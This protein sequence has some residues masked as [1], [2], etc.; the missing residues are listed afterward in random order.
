VFPGILLVACDRPPAIVGFIAPMTGPSANI[1]V[2]GV[3]GASLAVAELNNQGG[4]LGRKV[5]LRIKDDKGDPKSSLA[6]LEE[7]YGDGIRTILYHSTSGAA[8]LVFQRAAELPILVLTHTV[9]DPRWI[10]IKDSILRFVG[11]IQ[12]FA[13]SLGAF[14]QS[15]GVRTVYVALDSRNAAYANHFIQGFMDAA[16]SIA[17]AGRKEFADSWSPAA[18]ARDLAVSGAD[19]LLLVA[20]G[21][22]AAKTA[23]ELGAL[24]Y[25][26]ILFLSPWSQDQSL[27]TYSGTFGSRIFFPGSFDPEHAAPAYKK[28]REQYRLLYAETPVMAGTYG[29]QIVQFLRT[30]VRSSRSFDPERILDA[31]LKLGEFEGLQYPV[32]LDEYGDARSTGLVMTVDRGRFASVSSPPAPREP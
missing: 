1:G 11:G 29:Y 21:I 7:L 26:G 16:P 24:G 25:G 15:K 3:K 18:L 12:D 32:A 13:L 17:V 10:G 30:A 31:F 5:E 27:L 4:L 19:A 14:A 20:P 22:D 2:E 23:Q 8:E 28:F 6:A 9:S